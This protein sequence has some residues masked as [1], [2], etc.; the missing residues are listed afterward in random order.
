MSLKSWNLSALSIFVAFSIL[1]LSARSSRAFRKVA[2]SVTLPTAF[3]IFFSILASS[4]FLASSSFFF[5]A[6]RCFALSLASFANAVAIRLGRF[7][8]LVSRRKRLTKGFDDAV[9]D[10]LSELLAACGRFGA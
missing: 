4:F 8:Q 10:K 5:S 6:S 1:A 9:E 3:S 7:G 2:M